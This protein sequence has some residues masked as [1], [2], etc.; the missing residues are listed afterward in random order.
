[1]LAFVDPACGPCTTLLP[2]IATWQHDHASRLTIA[3]VS[4]GDPDANRTMAR[5]HGVHNVA[6][7]TDEEV[8]SAY[9]Y[10]G[11]PSAVLVNPDGRIASPLVAGVA[12]IRGLLQQTLGDSQPQLLNVDP[13]SG[14]SNTGDP[15]RGAA[16]IGDPSRGRSERIAAGRAR[17]VAKG[18]H[19]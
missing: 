13:R 3:L 15:P 12:A 17:P 5:E 7:Q 18:E 14:V 11:T 2:E 16:T 8:A 19:P 4:H 6:L 10:V 1:M 9:R